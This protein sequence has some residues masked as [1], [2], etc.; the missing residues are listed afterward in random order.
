MFTISNTT[1]AGD[2]AIMMYKIV[3]S[4][5]FLSWNSCWY[6]IPIAEIGHIPHSNQEP[7]PSLGNVFNDNQGVYDPAMKRYIIALSSRW[8]ASWRYL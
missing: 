8:N 3:E 2:T 4:N 5:L 1:N 6:K 7:Q